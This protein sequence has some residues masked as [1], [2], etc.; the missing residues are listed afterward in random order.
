MKLSILVGI[1][2][3]AQGKHFS[4]DSPLTYHE[5]IVALSHG[6]ALNEPGIKQKKSSRQVVPGAAPWKKLKW[7]PY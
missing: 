4:T 1:F 7:R 2:P 3:L 5:E 6:W